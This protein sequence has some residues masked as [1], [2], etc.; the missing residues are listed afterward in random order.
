ML[1]KS[2]HHGQ[3]TH[4]ELGKTRHHSRL[5]LLHNGGDPAQHIQVLLSQ[6]TVRKN[7]TNMMCHQ[8]NG[9]EILSFV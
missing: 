3:V 9:T 6:N 2:H 8:N 4:V 1:C 5:M 7:T